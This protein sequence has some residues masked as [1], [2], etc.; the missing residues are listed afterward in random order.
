MNA[1]SP[2]QRRPGQSFHDA[3][4]DLEVA[5]VD[6]V[7]QAEQR[8]DSRRLAGRVAHANKQVDTAFIDHVLI[9]LARVSKS[10]DVDI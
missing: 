10:T 1:A 6:H 3:G 9:W 8:I 2:M 7:S 5:L 4:L